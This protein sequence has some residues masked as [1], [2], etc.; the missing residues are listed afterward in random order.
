MP[1][2]LEVCLESGMSEIGQGQDPPMTHDRISCLV[3]L[4]SSPFRLLM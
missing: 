4:W 3:L 2:V 1:C